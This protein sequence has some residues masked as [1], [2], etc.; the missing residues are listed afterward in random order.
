[1]RLFLGVTFIYAGVQKLADPQFFKPT[2]PGFIGRQIIGF[3]HGS[4]LHGFLLQFVVPH[5]HFFGVLVIAGEIAIGLGTL[6]GFLLR[7]AAFFGLL[8]SLMFFLTA[9]WH[10]YPYFYGADIV[11]IF[12]WLT[13][14]LA[15]PAKTGYPALDTLWVQW[16]LS[17]G[18]QARYAPALSLLLGVDESAK[19]VPIPN[20]DVPMTGNAVPAQNRRG[21]VNARPN[22]QQGKARPNQQQS[23]YAAARRSKESRRNFLLGTV[24]GGVGM[25]GLAWLWNALHIFSGLSEDAPASTSTAT[26]TS[27]TAGS[28]A[29]PSAGGTAIAQVSQVKNNSS[30]SF[31][32]ASNGDPGILVRLNDGNFVCYD[33]TCTHAGCPVD[34]DPS[35]QLLVCPCHGAEFDPSKSA[36]VVQGPTDTPLTNVPIHVDNA[37]GAI[38]VQQ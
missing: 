33:A 22:Q 15:G 18:Q 1:M 9:S 2:A 7:P 14:L 16:L 8:I 10:V 17:P 35:S 30:V 31:T 32:L 6:V 37:S 19:G 21:P 38:T 34:Y 26:A 27:N 29:T 28:T 3:A 12:C 5:S 11:F 4:P 23:K 25:L 13:L 24:T 36:A 20:N